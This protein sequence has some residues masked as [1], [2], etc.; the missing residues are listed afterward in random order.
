V[1]P[2]LTGAGGRQRRCADHAGGEWALTDHRSPRCHRGRLERGPD[3]SI[4][5]DPSTAVRPRVVGP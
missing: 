2:V 4:V 5:R 3:G 1:D